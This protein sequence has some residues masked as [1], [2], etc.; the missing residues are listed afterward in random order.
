MPRIVEESRTEQQYVSGLARG[1]KTGGFVDSL[2]SELIHV[3]LQLVA[4]TS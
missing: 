1:A 4:F 2:L 3:Y